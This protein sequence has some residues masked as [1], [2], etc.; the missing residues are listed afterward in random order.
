MLPGTLGTSFEG[1]KK[2]MKLWRDDKA[3]IERATAAMTSEDKSTRKSCTKRATPCTETSGLDQVLLWVICLPKALSLGSLA[4]V[5]EWCKEQ[6]MDSLIQL[7]NLKLLADGIQWV[8]LIRGLPS[9]E[10]LSTFAHAMVSK[11]HLP[12]RTEGDLPYCVLWHLFSEGRMPVV[13]C[14]E[15]PLSTTRW[16]EEFSELNLG[17]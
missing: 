9:V 11:Y 13:L 12:C 3:S 10:E 17:R 5:P 16:L 4:S 6:K 2:K 1:G 15:E 14:L 8:D 7:W